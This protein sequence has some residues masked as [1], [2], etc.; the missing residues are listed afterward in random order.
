LNKYTLHTLF[1]FSK[2]HIPTPI[3]CLRSRAL[4][5]QEYYNR[6]HNHISKY[7]NHGDWLTHVHRVRKVAV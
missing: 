3:L 4:T 1:T 6:L 7:Y 5:T 2:E